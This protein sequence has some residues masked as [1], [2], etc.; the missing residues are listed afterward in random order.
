LTIPGSRTIWRPPEGSSSEAADREVQNAKER[1]AKTGSFTCKGRNIERR[2]VSGYRAAGDSGQ[3]AWAARELKDFFTGLAKN[4]RARK[5]GINGRLF[6]LGKM[7]FLNFFIE[8][9]NIHDT[10]P[11]NLPYYEYLPP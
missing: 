5:L 6:C 1:R 10:V 8:T 4:L 11:P 7:F 9:V 3:F 2:R